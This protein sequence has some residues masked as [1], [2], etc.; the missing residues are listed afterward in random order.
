[1]ISRLF[2]QLTVGLFLFSV[3]LHA[4]TTQ[5]TDPPAG[6]DKI[7]QMVS[8]RD[9]VRLATDVYRPDAPGT[10]PA[11]LVRSPY[12]KDV[13]ADEGIFFAS[14]GYV[15][16]AQDTRGRYA[17]E[18]NFDI[19]VQDDDDGFDTAQWLNGQPWFSA[20]HGFAVY[21]ASYLASTAISAEAATS[22]N[23]AS[24]LRVNMDVSPVIVSVSR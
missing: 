9:G 21:G 23:S 22:R 16:V 3:P 12:D 15:Y 8:M 4:Q 6:F 14:A 18:G 7:E 20:E 13:L 5:P 2:L 19:Y 24:R 11:I 10:F 17:S 1:M